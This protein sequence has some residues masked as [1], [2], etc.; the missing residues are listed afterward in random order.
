MK[1]DVVAR[2]GVLFS[3][4]VSSVVVPAYNGEM[5]ILPGREPIMAVVHKGTVRFVRSDGVAQSINIGAGFVTVDED[6]ISVVVENY[7][8]ETA[9]EI[10]GIQS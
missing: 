8:D 7:D 4:E 1:L 2:S 5:G 6:H 9:T 3:G 10:A